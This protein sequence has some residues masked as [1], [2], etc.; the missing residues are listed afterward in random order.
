MV[1]RSFG[2]FEKDTFGFLANLSKN[3]KK[4]WFDENR[5]RYDAYWKTPALNLIDA[6]VEPMKA[7]SPGL[8]AEA[9]IN[10]SL[11]RINRDVRFSKDKSP[12]KPRIHLTFWSGSHPNRSP[13]FHLVLHADKIGYGAGVFGIGAPELAAYRNRIVDPKDR[14]DLLAAIRNAEA[15]GCDFDDPDLVNLPKGFSADADWEHLLRRK[16]YVMRTLVDQ[17][18]PDWISSDQ[19]VPEIMKRA[20]AISP[21]LA[22]L[23]KS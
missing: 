18:M 23:S 11:R 16:S 19:A 4:E 13:G 12:Y 1:T 7:L 21:F 2:G 10:G 22:W 9:R 8:K 3:N 5:G 6:L 14:Q 20:S 17:K 15:V